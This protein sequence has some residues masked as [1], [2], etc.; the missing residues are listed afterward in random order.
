MSD[1]YAVAGLSTYCFRLA[2]YFF[3]LI[4]RFL[5]HS[6]G[7]WRVLRTIAQLLPNINVAIENALTLKVAKYIAECQRVLQK[8]GLTFKVQ[9]YSVCA[10]L[11]Q[12]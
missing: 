2:P 11:S 12:Y 1:L 4:F 7:H 5:S 3:F 9:S 8:T 6:N 10:L